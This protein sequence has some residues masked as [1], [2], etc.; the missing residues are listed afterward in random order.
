MIFRENRLLTVLV[1]LGLIGAAWSL[2]GRYASEVQNRAVEVAVD[3]A[4]VAQ[5]AGA[6][7][8]TIADALARL[9]ESG[10]TSV[11]VQEGTVA[12]LAASGIVVVA[13][14]EPPAQGSEIWGDTA[15][16]GEALV[17][18]GLQVTAAR[19]ET[20]EGTVGG[21]R[22]NAAPEYVLAL[23]VGLP[24]EAV[25]AAKQAGVEVIARLV[26]Y[27]RVE[28]RDVERTADELKRDGVRTV[29]FAAD[30]VL[31]FRGGIDEV[32]DVLKS[33]GLDYGSIEFAKQKGD[34]RFSEKM[35]PNVVRVHS[36]TAAEM[37]TLDRAEAIERFVRGAKERNIRLAY[38]RMFDLSSS[39][40]L[41]TNMEYVAAIARGLKKQ[42]FSLQP[43][44]PFRD[45][46]APLAARVLIAI[47]AAAGTLLLALSVVKGV[48]KLVWAAFLVLA[49]LFAAAVAPGMPLGLKLVALIVAIVFPTLAVLYAARGALPEPSQAPL[50]AYLGPAAGRF[51]A[52]VAITGAGALMIAGLL[53]RLEFMLH[54]EQFAGVKVAQGAPILLLALAFAAGIG[55]APGG[56]REQ[57]ERA[58]ANLR[59]AAGQPVL[60][61][62]SAIAV[63]LL[64]MVALLLA[65]S[66][67]E[68]GVGVSGFELRVRALLDNLLFVRPRTKEFLIGH[69]ALVIGIAAALGGR[70][71]WAALFLVVG[72]VGE[73]SLLN[74]F[75]HIHTPIAVSVT[76]AAIGAALGLGIGA[77]LLLV[78]SRPGKAAGRSGTV[79]T[80]LSAPHRL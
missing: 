39:D 12:D 29:V 60:F 1:G 77:L 21:V 16:V 59:S 78:F 13:G 65:R 57:K 64:V 80:E 4:E 26:N 56:W 6:S 15:D 30:Q 75:C 41:R 40:P 66:G 79:E 63:V 9:K 72:A 61:W 34:Q 7:G 2:A 68:P 25:D 20:P 18:R 36:V 22:V 46:K 67:N 14:E 53:S 31:G 45:P 23:P 47:G 50:R 19:F 76:R 8:M 3:Y 27:P 24:D 37:G 33:R 5:L 69:P 73:V 71:S 42:G 17:S 44:H 62:Q 43:D 28:R 48:R 52:A 32:A 54:V 49:A 35:L 55:W 51:V 10:V 58:L 38:V 74:T 70:R 11:A